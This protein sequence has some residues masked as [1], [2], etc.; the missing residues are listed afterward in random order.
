MTQVRASKHEVARQI[1]TG[2]H[3]P[4]ILDCLAQLSNDEVPT[5]PKLARAMLDILPDDVWGKA[6]YVWLDPFCKSGIFLR[7]AA[8]RLLEGLSDQIPDFEQR[9]DHIYRNMLWGTSITEMT[10]MIS[11]RSLYYSRDAAGPASVVPFD[12]EEGNLPF[13]RVRHTYPKKKDGTVTGGCTV[14]GA[15]FDLERGEARENYAYSFI[16][17]AYPT[18]ELKD[19]K[20]DVIVGNPPYQI[21]SDGNTRTKPVYHLFVQQAIAM[22]PRYAVMITPSRWFAGGLGLDEFR[23][24]MLTGGR[25]DRLVDYVDPTDCFPGVDIQ[26]GVSFFRWDREHTGPTRISAANRDGIEDAVSRPLDE[27]DIFVRDNH[28]V[29]IIRKVRALEE[30]TLDKRV[31]KRVPFGLQS[32]FKSAK[33][34]HITVIGRNRTSQ[35]AGSADITSNAT[36]L[37]KHKVLMP[38]GYGERGHGP[39]LVLGKPFIAGPGTACTDTYVV[40]GVFE[41]EGE[42]ENYR[43]YLGLRLPRFLVLQRKISQHLTN[44]RFAFVP[45]LP[46]DRSWSDADLY[47]RYGLSDDEIAYVESRIRPLN[48]EGDINE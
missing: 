6:D 41:T 19:M 8:G 26:A 2:Q 29:P 4:D 17:G 48:G 39:Y 30:S 36:W 37:D 12:G 21:D 22:K 18:E 14:C 16:H 42:A 24:Q 23:Q 25:I 9:R 38:V 44:D 47:E 13:I 7:E 45:D 28:A 33:S 31:S 10:G 34:G 11:R 43:Q 35:T 3:I 15:P 5:P 46:M 20:F 27:F 1:R 40:A 32:N